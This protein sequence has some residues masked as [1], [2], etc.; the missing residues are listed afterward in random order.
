MMRVDYEDEDLELLA[1]VST[2]ITSRWPISVTRAFRRRIQQL[3]ALVSEDNLWGLKAL[4]VHELQDGP[5]SSYSI[6]IQLQY[7]LIFRFDP[8]NDKRLVIMGTEES[9]NHRQR[10]DIHGTAAR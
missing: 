4:H 6:R 2:H 3:S 5:E 8:D 1:Y 7:R 9:A 10:S